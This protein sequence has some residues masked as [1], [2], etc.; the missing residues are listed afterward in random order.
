MAKKNKQ[1]VLAFFESE[2]AAKQAAEGLKQW[3]KAHPDVKAGAVGVI[4]KDAKG[5]VKEDLLGPRAGKKGAGIGLI[6]GVIAAVPD[7][8]AQPARRRSG[9]RG[10]RRGRGGV[11]PQTPGPLG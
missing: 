9:R 3:D 11:L 10:R 4:A 1:L 7:R 2:T 8:R 6:L 5:K